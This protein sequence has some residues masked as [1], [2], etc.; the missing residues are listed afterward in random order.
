MGY[1]LVSSFKLTDPRVLQIS[2]A[3]PVLP[4]G[5]RIASRPSL[6]EVLSALQGP[7]DVALAQDEAREVFMTDTGLTSP[8]ASLGAGV[9]FPSARPAPV[10]A[11]AEAA[12][13]MATARCRAVSQ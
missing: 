13:H 5:L 8:S 10:P 1:G 2:D 11:R 9:R 4:A 3:P 6:K 7:I 12:M